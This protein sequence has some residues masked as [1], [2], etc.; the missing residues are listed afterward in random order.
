MPVKMIIKTPLAPCS[1]V[2]PETG[3]HA[4]HGR[5]TAAVLPRDAQ[6]KGLKEH[7]QNLVLRAGQK[8]FRQGFGSKDE[9]IKACCEASWN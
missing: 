6:A 4:E 1:L 7:P 2:R 9:A 5:Q 3:C 8:H